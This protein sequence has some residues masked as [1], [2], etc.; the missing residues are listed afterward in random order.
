L[1]LKGKRIPSL[2]EQA[3]WNAIA[4]ALCALEAVIMSIVSSRVL[5]L[6]ATGELTIAFAFGNLFRTIGLWGIRNYHLS[7]LRF[8]YSFNE[9]RKARYF[10]IMLMLIAIIVNALYLLLSASTIEKL[11]VVILIEAVYLLECYEDLIGGEYQRRGRLDIGAKLFLIR[12]SS[13]LLVYSLS[14]YLF[15]SLVFALLFS[16]VISSMLFFITLSYGFGLPKDLEDRKQDR[17][18]LS[19][20]QKKL[21]LTTFPLFLISFLTFFL[22]N[23]AKYSLDYYYEESIQACFGFIA[24]SIF[25]VEMISGFLYQPKLTRISQ[26]WIEKR[27]KDFWVEIVKQIF[28]ILI[29]TIICLLGG[30][31]IGVPVL[32]FLFSTDLSPYKVDLLINIIAGGAMSYVMYAS[33]LLTIMRKQKLQLYIYIITTILG[34]LFIWETVKLHCIRGGSFG[35]LI[36]FVIQAVAMNIAVFATIGHNKKS[37]YKSEG[38]V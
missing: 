12:W 24:L 13:L 33:A 25:A 38:K 36:V 37:E 29:I 26:L 15:K 2:R 4:G 32:S 20:K 1:Q 34:S 14:V 18:L 22:N 19:D 5:G 8:E 28:L 3:V 11:L 27:I 35:N 31:W 9:Y 7:D 17:G 16:V 10:S 21:L 23:I 6:T 30:W